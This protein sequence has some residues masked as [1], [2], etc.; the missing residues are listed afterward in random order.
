MNRPYLASRNHSSRF[1]RAGSGG[2]GAC[3]PGRPTSNANAVK[4]AKSCFIHLSE[5]QS[6]RKLHDARRPG[7]IG[8]PDHGPEVG[9]DL[10]A[11][12]VEPRR[13]VDVLEL[14]LV[15]E[16]VDLGAELCGPASAEAHVLEHREVRVVH[17]RLADGV[18]RRVA[19]AAF[20]GTPERRGIEVSGQ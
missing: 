8:D 16:I 20:G 1:S 5:V 7:G 6:Y 2:L 14:H 3:A 17:A 10:R 9:V 4:A 15:E 12:G 13:A 18:A 11:R 19:V